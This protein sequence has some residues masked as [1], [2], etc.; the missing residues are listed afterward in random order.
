MPAEPQLT[1]QQQL[2]HRGFP[3]LLTPTMA[4]CMRQPQEQ[5]PIYRQFWPSAEELQNPPHYTTDPLQEAASSP[6][7]GLV[8]KY[9]G[10][11]LLHLT[12]ACPVHCRYCFRRHG[13][14]TSPMDPQAEQQ[15]VDHLAQDH[16]LQEII[17]SGGDPLMLNAPK[18][19]WWM[20][21]L[22]QLPHLQRIRIHSRVPVADP[23]RLTIP[24]LETLQNTAKSVVLV[25]HCNHAQELT[26]ASEVALQACRQAGFLVLNQSVLLAGVNDS[27]EILAKLNLALVGLGVLPYYLHLLD[28]VQGAAHFEVSPQRAMEIMRQLHQCLPGYALPKLVRERPELPGKEPIHWF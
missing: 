14:I 3:M 27:A 6:M 9:Q 7:P 22:A 16:T 2:A 20:T 15:L 13:A 10:R 19:H 21:Q 18:W 5:D 12:D 4:D 23:S 17:L 11:A 1:P 24:M 28:T 25:I 8:H 26:P